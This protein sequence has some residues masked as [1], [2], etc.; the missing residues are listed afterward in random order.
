[1]KQP[2]RLTKR[3]LPCAKRE[4][5]ARKREA[6]YYTATGALHVV[7]RIR[8]DIGLREAAIQRA[9]RRETT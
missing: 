8:D 4:L 5:E 9:E 7:E 3:M 2:Y 6:A 1:M